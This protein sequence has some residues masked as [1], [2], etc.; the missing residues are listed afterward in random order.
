MDQKIHSSPDTLEAIVAIMPL[1]IKSHSYGEYVFDWSWAEAYHR[2][3]MEY[4]PKLVSAVP[5]TP[6]TGPRWIINQSYSFNEIIAFM[7]TAITK[8]TEEIQASSC[9]CLFSFNERNNEWIDSDKNQRW[10]KRTGYQYHW[11]NQSYE[12]FEDFL[13]SMSSR[14]RK[15]IK[16]E[17]QKIQQQNIQVDIKCGNDISSDDW[18]NFYIFYQL[19][20]IKKS[21]HGGY[22]SSD[23][24]PILA[25]SMP[26]NIV[27]ITAAINK[28][29]TANEQYETVAA[30][31]YFKDDKTLYGRYWG[32]KEDFD[33]LHFELCYYQ[34][35]EFAIAN[36][37]ARFDPGAQ[38]EHKI[39]RGFTPIKTYSSHWIK[40]NEF[41]EA[42][43]NFVRIEER[44]VESYIEEAKQLLPFK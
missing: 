10:L 11:H 8:E 42:I 24:F 12:S 30:A 21:G 33:G 17:R 3:G 13:A 29:L 5:F 6:A 14:K 1:F 27:M 34:G 4:Y 22:L 38:G 25:K 40:N 15:N 18:H 7:Q 37:L 16:K 43:K 23:F 41:H 31:L 28:N 44:E 9:H 36:K 35:I 39:K 20:Y 2:H 32:C 19:T 26:Q